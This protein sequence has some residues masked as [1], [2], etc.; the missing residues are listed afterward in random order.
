MKF[1][2]FLLNENKIVLNQKVGDILNALQELSQDAKQI[3]TRSLVKNSEIIVS[4]MRAIL[5]QT[6]PQ[7][8]QKEIKLIQKCAISLM[9]AID[10]K[11]DLEEIINKCMQNLQNIGSS[12][13]INNLAT[14]ENI[15]VPKKDPNESPAGLGPSMTTK[16]LQN[17]PPA[18]GQ[19]QATTDQ[20]NL[21][22]QQNQQLQTGSQISPSTNQQLLNQL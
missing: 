12:T 9:K 4:K 15:D 1:K 3:G 11:S 2:E 19:L 16:P 6:W 18:T 7:S 8:S 22:N 20:Q 10:E 14:P 17:P 21:T 5:H 13:P